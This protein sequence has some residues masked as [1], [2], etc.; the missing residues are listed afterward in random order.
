M[1]HLKDDHFL[2]EEK[3]PAMTSKNLTTFFN[4]SRPG[5]S[6]SDQS[7]KTNKWIL[8]RDL[9]LWFCRS[10]MPFNSVCDEGFED[11]LKKYNVIY[12]KEDLP[13]RTTVSREGLNDIYECMLA[14]IKNNILENVG[15]HAAL[16]TDLW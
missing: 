2:A 3:T 14:H 5:K 7:T 13:A 1:R 11:F 9:A 15:S 16:T 8:A 10:L 6:I 4:V 12:K